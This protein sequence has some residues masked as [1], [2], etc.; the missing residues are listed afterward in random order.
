MKC[1]VVQNSRKVSELSHAHGPQLPS[2]NTVFHGVESM[3]KDTLSG[4]STQHF[5]A[6][7]M[8]ARMNSTDARVIVDRCVFFMMGGV[9]V[10]QYG[11]GDSYL[12]SHASLGYVFDERCT[13]LADTNVL[14]NTVGPN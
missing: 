10:M 1:E 7:L 14:G 6:F 4:S 8:H 12:Y 2:R 5:V 3:L 11:V 9:G 13:C